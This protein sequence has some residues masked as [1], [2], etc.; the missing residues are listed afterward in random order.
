MLILL[1]QELFIGEIFDSL[2][3]FHF[4]E[5]ITILFELRRKVLNVQKY[6]GTK[7]YIGAVDFKLFTRTIGL[8]DSKSTKAFSKYNTYF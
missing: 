1:G 3:V 8:F 5:K 2:F 6:L 4:S 7:V